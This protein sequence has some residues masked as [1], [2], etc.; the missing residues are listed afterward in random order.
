MPG[1]RFAL[2]GEKVEDSAWLAFPLPDSLQTAIFAACRVKMKKPGGPGF[3]FS[4]LL[5][6]FG[7]WMPFSAPGGIGNIA[8]PFTDGFPASCFRQGGSVTLPGRCGVRI[9]PRFWRPIPQRQPRRAPCHFSPASCGQDR[10]APAPCRAS[11][12]GKRKSLSILQAI[13]TADLS[14]AP[15]H[16]FRAFPLLRFVFQCFRQD[17]KS[18][19]SPP[20]FALALR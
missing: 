10:T 13:Q 1:W 15:S 5:S 20:H 3:M 8:I 18:R 7:K 19:H 9:S 6:S 4:E 14:P 2:S 16:F 12:R 17:R 11:F